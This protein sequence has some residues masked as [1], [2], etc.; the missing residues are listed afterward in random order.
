LKTIAGVDINKNIFRNYVE[1]VYSTPDQAPYT[2]LFSM[3]KEN[4]EKFKDHIEFVVMKFSSNAYLN[5]KDKLN[6]Y[7]NDLCNSL[8]LCG[9]GQ[10]EGFESFFDII[11]YSEAEADSQS[12]IIVAS[13]IIDPSTTDPALNSAIVDLPGDSSDVG[14]IFD[15]YIK[16]FIARIKYDI[17]KEVVSVVGKN[18][19]QSV[20]VLNF[21]KNAL[22]DYLGLNFKIVSN[23][24][25]FG[26]DK[27]KEN[28][29]KCLTAFYNEFTP[30]HVIKLLTEDLNKNK[31]EKFLNEI[32]KKQFEAEDR[33]KYP[34]SYFEYSDFYPISVTTEFIKYH[35]IEK[36]IIIE[37]RKLQTYWTVC[38]NIFS[39]FIKN[40]YP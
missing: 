3:R 10:L 24:G 35:L 1:F 30:E 25:V 6:N 23:Y 20:H 8:G 34:E 36:N 27:F 33:K 32:L 38:S 26:Q 5:D 39:S 16:N 4:Q 15:F 40:F 7:F 2:N 19:S 13:P 12:S 21:W 11:A 29:L 14:P 22:S 31:K 9:D 18:D 28:P 17:L 37:K